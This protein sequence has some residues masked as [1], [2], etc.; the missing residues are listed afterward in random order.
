MK[1]DHDQDSAEKVDLAVVQVLVILTRKVHLSREKGG[2]ER[3]NELL[4]HHQTVKS[5]Y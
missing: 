2:I 3:N 4:I 5:V 1:A